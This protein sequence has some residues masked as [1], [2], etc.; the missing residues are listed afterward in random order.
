MFALVALMGGRPLASSTTFFT[1]R[2]GAG[3]YGYLQDLFTHAD[4]RGPGV[5]RALIEAVQDAAAREGASRVYWL[6]HETNADAMKL[7]DKVAER[8]GCVHYR[9]M[10]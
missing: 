1:G 8:T 2:A 3:P 10:V 6:T 9:K 7:Y 4:C 5:G